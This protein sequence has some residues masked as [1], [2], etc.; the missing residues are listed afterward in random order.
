M[1]FFNGSDI[2]VVSLEK[3]YRERKL[4]I[5]EEIVCS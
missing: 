3:R 2:H 1:L 5:L 4:I